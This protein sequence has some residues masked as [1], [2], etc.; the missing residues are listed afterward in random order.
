ML[1]DRENHEIY[2]AEE[3]GLPNW[4]WCVEGSETKQVTCHIYPAQMPKRGTGCTWV[5]TAF[6]DSDTISRFHSHILQLYKPIRGTEDDPQGDTHIKVSSGKWPLSTLIIIHQMLP[7]KKANTFFW[8]FQIQNIN[9][10]WLP[11]LQSITVAQL[12]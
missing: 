9:S 7:S 1:L 12:I 5:F 10:Q 3:L 4:G 2:T 6:H 11:K 8:E